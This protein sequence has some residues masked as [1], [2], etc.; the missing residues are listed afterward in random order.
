MT[1]IGVYDSGIGGLTT[2][3]ILPEKFGESRFYYLSDN[4]NH[5]FGNKKQSDMEEIVYNGVRKLKCHCD[6]PVLACN[7]ASTAYNDKNVFLLL[8]PT[9]RIPTQERQN[10]L[11]MATPNTLKRI[12]DADFKRADTE[13]LASLI[14]IQ[15]AISA[16]NGNLDMQNTLLYLAKKVF[17]FKGVK[18][19]IL[20][21]SHYPYCKKQIT[22]ILGD[23]KYFDGNKELCDQLSQY[24]YPKDK[25]LCENSE[26]LRH[27]PQNRITVSY[28]TSDYIPIAKRIN[29]DM[30]EFDFTGGNESKSY[31]KILTLLMASDI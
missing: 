26:K 9:D 17:P 3:K 13:E 2:L 16:R 12:P 5:P 20:G 24:I 28:E 6:I 18:N 14:E 30:L 19:V 4:A 1:T 8:P 11:L 10:T 22:K 31:K 15:A 23:V 25:T 7:T 29:S 21:C 27:T